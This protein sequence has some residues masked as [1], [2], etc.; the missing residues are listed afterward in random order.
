MTSSQ[1]S[2]EMARN[3]AFVPRPDFLSP[4]FRLKG[5]RN[6]EN[7]EAVDRDRFMFIMWVEVPSRVDPATI[8]MYFVFS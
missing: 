1:F 8:F 4:S 6:V 2:A 5:L 3:K 7:V